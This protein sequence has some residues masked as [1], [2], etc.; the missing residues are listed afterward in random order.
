MTNDVSINSVFLV[1]RL[2]SAPRTSQNGQS[3]VMDLEVDGGSGPLPIRVTA[4]RI[5]PMAPIL[6]VGHMV[7]VAGRLGTDCRG[8]VILVDDTHGAV[9]QIDRG[10]QGHAAHS[11]PVATPVHVPVHQAHVPMSTQ[12]A[13]AP[14][15]PAPVAVAPE[16]SPAPAA[17]PQAAAAVSPV[18]H[19]SIPPAAVEHAPVE[20]PAPQAA[21]EASPA[22]VRPSPAPVPAAP[23]QVETPPASPAPAH[24]ASPVRP[25]AA[26]PAGLRPIPGRPPA[27]APTQPAAAPADAHAPIEEVD[28]LDEPSAAPAPAPVHRP[29]VPG[30]RPGVAA[31]QPARLPPGAA[32]MRPIGQRAGLGALRAAAPAVDPA[33]EMDHEDGAPPARVPAPQPRPAGLSAAHSAGGLRTAN[34][35]PGGGFRARATGVA[36]PPGPQPDDDDVPF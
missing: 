36:A 14:A 35:P 15:A 3:G 30:M 10:F 7:E 5:I 18:V 20:D 6:G 27:A 32:T 11:V 21:P 33:G 22:A 8:P 28:I 2:T 23:V 12:P 25:T 1:G 13:P 9:R 29:P 24:Q 26:S 31:A 16:P 17:A 19:A 4:I 34:A